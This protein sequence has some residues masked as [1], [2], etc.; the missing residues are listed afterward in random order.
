MKKTTKKNTNTCSNKRFAK[1][2][3]DGLAN[4]GI[5]REWMKKHLIIISGK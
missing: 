2:M 4:K 1:A 3:R 5:S